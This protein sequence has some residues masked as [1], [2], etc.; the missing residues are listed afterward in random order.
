[1][2]RKLYSFILMFDCIT[3]SHIYFCT[4]KW[5]INMCIVY[6]SFYLLN[7]TQSQKRRGCVVEESSYVNKLRS[8]VFIFATTVW[9]LIRSEIFIVKF[10][11]QLSLWFMSNRDWVVTRV[12]SFSLVPCRVF[13]L[14][15]LHVLRP[16]DCSQPA[17]GVIT[18]SWSL[19]FLLSLNPV[20]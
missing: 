5:T 18:I 20:S 10:S 13:N 17:D 11:D 3:A 16:S 19:F 15:Y 6:F 1:M 2:F 9:T 7:L 4:I 8:F 14:V 12:L